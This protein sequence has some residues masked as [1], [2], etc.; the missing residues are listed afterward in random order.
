MGSVSQLSLKIEGVLEI[1]VVHFHNFTR[2]SEG[3]EIGLRLWG[4]VEGG[5]RFGNR[6]RRAKLFQWLL[7][8]T[9]YLGEMKP[10]IS[11]MFW[12][13]KKITSRDMRHPLKEKRSAREKAFL[14]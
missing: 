12:I 1:I 13:I 14:S 7:T 9:S 3:N 5:G 11:F 10:L 6:L 4:D 2:G 8:S